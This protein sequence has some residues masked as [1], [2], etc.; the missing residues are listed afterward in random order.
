[1]LH[2]IH[3][4][5]FFSFIQHVLISYKV[6]KS[7]SK[8]LMKNNDIF[9]FICIALWQGNAGTLNI[10]QGWNTLEKQNKIINPTK[11]K[12]WGNSGREKHFRI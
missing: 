11:S 2:L 9:N 1:M 5:I 8:T 4:Y 12:H 3:L 6:H 7:T 10:K